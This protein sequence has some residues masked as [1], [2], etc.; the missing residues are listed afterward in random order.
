MSR[1]REGEL[2]A[3][4]Q[5]GA[6][7]SRQQQHDHYQIR[8]LSGYPARISRGTLLA[9]SNGAYGTQLAALDQGIQV[10]PQSLPDGHVVLSI[11]QQHD[12]VSGNITANTQH[13]ATTLHVTPGQW[14][15][16]GSI[17]IDQSRQQRGIGGSSHQRSTL[18]LPIEVMVQISE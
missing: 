7:Q 13:S 11:Q 17:Q 8:T 10:T 15:P 6:Q 9:L 4:V 3:Q 12:T 1:N 16:M 14:H 2:D 5:I 18:V